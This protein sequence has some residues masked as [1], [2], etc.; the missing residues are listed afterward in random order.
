MDNELC[1][2]TDAFYLFDKITSFKCN[3]IW[4]INAVIYIFL[5]SKVSKSKTDISETLVVLSDSGIFTS[6]IFIKT[7]LGHLNT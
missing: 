7:I 3:L 6:G 2:W 4:F 5:K 1:L